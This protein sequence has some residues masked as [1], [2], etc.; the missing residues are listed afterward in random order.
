MNSFSLSVKSL[1]DGD[2]FIAN[3]EVVVEQGI[4]KDIV[5]RDKAVLNPLQ[6]ELIEDTLV[7]G[8][9]DVQVNG[10]GNCLFNQSPDYASL[11][12]IGQAHHQYGTTGWLP[13]L[14]TDSYEKMSLAADAVALAQTKELTDILGIH[15]EGPHLSINKKGIH[16]AEL[17]REISEKEIDI[18]C[19]QDLGKVVV[20]L[21]AENVAPQAIKKLV[22]AGVIVC[23]GHSD[24]SFEQTQ[25][26]LEAGASGFTHLFNAMSPM[27]SRAPGVVGAALLDQDSWCGLIVDGIHVHPATAQIALKAKDNIML[28][29]DAMP[30]VGSKKVSFEFFGQTITRDGDQLTDQQGRLAGSALDMASAVRNSLRMLNC[31]AARALNMASLNPAKFLGLE[32]QIGSLQIGKQANMVLLNKKCEVKSAWIDGI[33]VV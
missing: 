16:K 15:F 27:T 19:R 10:G 2:K 28:V 12:Q 3:S 20:T 4:I 9:I 25:L 22:E 5:V 23:L 17:V 30:P 18:F 7:A 6:N 8:F 14:V 26:A 31:S 11:L 32:L 24:A 1:F 21:A 29:T 13:T 33:Q